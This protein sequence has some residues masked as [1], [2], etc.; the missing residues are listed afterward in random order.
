MGPWWGPRVHS[1]LHW[2]PGCHSHLP[3]NNDVLCRDV[4]AVPCRACRAALRP[5]RVPQKEVI[6]LLELKRSVQAKQHLLAGMKRAKR[7][8]D[9]DETPRSEKRQRMGK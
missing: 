7:E 1:L 9:V 2:V 6:E 3:S 4:R 8:E 5:C